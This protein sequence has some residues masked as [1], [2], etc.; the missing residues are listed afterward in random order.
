M[1]ASPEFDSKERE[2]SAREH[3]GALIAP[4]PRIQ[5]MIRDAVWAGLHPEQI[6]EARLTEV[7]QTATSTNLSALDN[8]ENGKA[9]CSE[10]SSGSRRSM[11]ANS[12]RIAGTRRH[13]N[14]TIASFD[15]TCSA[16]QDE[17]SDDS[18]FS[19]PR[20][21]RLGASQVHAQLSRLTDRARLRRLTR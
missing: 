20:S 3:L 13:K 1:L 16:S 7:I 17:D 8:A 12:R 15:H 10:G 9:G 6:L 5:A 2:T 18:H 19:A 21:S 4:K 11:A 14:L